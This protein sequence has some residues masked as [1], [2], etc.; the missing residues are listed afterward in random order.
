MSLVV[1]DRIFEIDGIEVFERRVVGGEIDPNGHIY[2]RER[3]TGDEYGPFA[4]VSTAVEHFKMMR[5]RSSRGGGG[6]NSPPKPAAVGVL[7]AVDFKN[8]KRQENTVS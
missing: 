6:K 3:K 8:K 4:Y 7:I 2:W 1:E 5:S